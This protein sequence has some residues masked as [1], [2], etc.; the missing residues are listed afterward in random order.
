M[1]ARIPQGLIHVN[2]TQAGHKALIEEQWLQHTPVAQQAPVKRCS[3]EASVKR[4][5]A[6]MGQKAGRILNQ[7]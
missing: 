4:L 1:D 6:E 3:A 7:I 2:V 5:R